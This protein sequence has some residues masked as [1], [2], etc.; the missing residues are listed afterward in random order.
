MERG[1]SGAPHW[2]ALYVAAVAVWDGVAALAG[3][4]LA[5]YVRF[6]IEGASVH[7]PGLAIP[8]LVV[9]LTLAVAWIG[10]LALGGGYDAKELGSGSEEYR[11]VFNVG[12]RMLA[13]VAVVAFLARLNLARA[14][15]GI[16][17]P[18]TTLLTLTSRHVIRK[19]VH[20]RRAR[21]DMMNKVLVVGSVEPVT[22]LIRHLCS[23]PHAGFSVL[24]ACIPGPATVLDVDGIKVPIVG[25]PNDVEEVVFATE[26]DAVAIVG[27][28]A[29]EDGRLR[30]LGWRL[31]GTGIDLIVAPA[32][33]DIAG[34]RIVTRPVAG[35]PL[36][37][38]EEPELSG[39]VRAFKDL[40]DRTV[41]LLLILVTLP[42]WLV[43]AATIRLTSRGPAFFRQTRIGR[44]GEPF[45]VW[46]FRT[47]RP[48][49]EDELTALAEQNEADGLI[50]KIREDPRRTKVG[51]WLR[52]LSID[53]LPQLYNVL[54][55]DMSIVGPRPPL[56]SEVERY[57]DHVARRLL[58]KPGMTGL[59]QVSGRADLS[60]E[61]AVR[62]D[63]Y[64]V[65]N[66]SPAMD[67]MIL[68]RTISAVTSGRG[69][70]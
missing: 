59:W 56:P 29:L 39:A 16:A 32:L 63:V 8:Y 3:M 45:T 53:E 5:Q 68:W 36:L 50:F 70:Y 22:R 48:E 52:R 67:A 62:L 26:A 47:M 49:A 31:E 12:V 40:F 18:A 11:R 64:Y 66:W 14:Y 41:A 15:V 69:A 54:R 58:V 46:K 21:G 1:S 38:V 9:S 61:E 17:L 51:K 25:D 19:G 28:D 44:D 4:G 20:R 55:G 37:H 60:W 65:E 27:T 2:R 6:G 13:L 33:T 34:P 35:L 23:V 7:T 57:S 43:I 24:A 10:G 42:L 30:S